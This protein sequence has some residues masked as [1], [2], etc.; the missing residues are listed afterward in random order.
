MND[1]KIKLMSEAPVT[2]AIFK[3]SIPMVMGMM[4]Q[5]FYNLVD[6]FFVG[7]LGDANQLAAANMALP[8]FMM[9]MALASIIGTGASSYISRCLGNKDY[10]KAN[11]TTTLAVALLVGLSLLI[12]AGGLLA[13]N[14]IVK[15][16]GASEAT[17]G[18][19]KQYVSIMFLGS[20]GVVCNYA[21]GQLLRAEGD[22]MKAMIGMMIGTVVN[23]ILDPIF[24]FVLNLGVAGAAL[25][26]VIGNLLGLAYYIVSFAKG[27]T[28]L[29]IQ[30]SLLKYEPVI[31]KEMMKIGLPSSLNQLLMSFAIVLANQI[32]M[33]YG[34]LTVAGMGV[35]MKII[36]IGTF[37]FMGFSA[38][39]QPLVGFNYGGKNMKRVEA[40][41][42]KGITITSTIGITLAIL[43]GI[44]A[45]QL[46]GIF[47]PEEEVVSIGASFLKVLILSL[48]FIGSQMVITSSIQAMGKALPAFILS[49]ARQGILY[50]PLLL[51]LNRLAGIKGFIFAQP[52]TDVIMIV[53]SATIV[54]TILK[55]EHLS[56][57]G[58]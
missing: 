23:I 43:F 25:A 56:H 38:G 5:V 20:I 16:L 48:P 7:R 54:F 15:A 17:F 41:I 40:I 26:T 49:I 24:I 31:L 27:K 3:M 14:P 9:L 50:M 52:I 33:S 21:F 58:V 12:T 45:S 28:F 36:T 13:I 34:E 30:P 47:T 6:T 32:A 22:A 29:R 53:I 51:L 19:T 57:K 11:Q 39:C 55:K 18:F 2:Q 1:K 37:I 35:A 10:E 4:V 44:F 42:K 46:I 8:I